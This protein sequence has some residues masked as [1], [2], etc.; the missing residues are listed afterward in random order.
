MVS[1]S[2]SKQPEFLRLCNLIKQKCKDYRNLTVKVIGEDDL[3][4]KCYDAL[5]EYLEYFQSIMSLLLSSGQ[6]RSKIKKLGPKALKQLLVS[7]LSVIEYSMRNIVDFYPNSTLYI[8]ISE[9]KSRGRK[10]YIKDVVNVSSNLGIIDEASRN[11]WV[12]VIDI[13]NLLVHNNAICDLSSDKVVGGVRIRMVEGEPL[14]MKPK[15]IIRLIE[16]VINEFHKWNISMHNN[17]SSAYCCPY[18]NFKSMNRRALE[19]H[20]RE[21]HPYKG[22]KK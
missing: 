11:N 17:Y 22:G 6:T 1:E 20:I 14:E 9:W 3:R 18:C 10:V 13:R 12:N 15:D 7:V 16:I 4:A 2:P 5:V 21:K 19:I 8:K